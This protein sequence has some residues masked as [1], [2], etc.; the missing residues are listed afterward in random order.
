MPWCTESSNSSNVGFE[1]RQHQQAILGMAKEHIVEF[2]INAEFN[3]FGYYLHRVW[4]GDRPSPRSLKFYADF[5]TDANEREHAKTNY[6]LLL[7]SVLPHL[8]QHWLLSDLE[9]ITRN[10][11]LSRDDIGS[12]YKIH[13]AEQMVG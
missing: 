12:K 1:S 8:Q 13:K 9:P 3:M 2:D 11:R 4:M 5:G 7:V 10:R 6:I